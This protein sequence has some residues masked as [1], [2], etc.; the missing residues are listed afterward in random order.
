MKDRNFHFDVDRDG[1]FK[2]NAPDWEYSHDDRL[3][4]NSETGPFTISARRIDHSPWPGNISTPVDN[5][6]SHQ[7]PTMGWVAEVDGIEDGLTPEERREARAASAPADPLFIAKYKYI[8]AALHDKEI[9]IND[10]MTGTYQC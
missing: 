5:L 7:D 8:I 2:F 6:H 3:I 9:L 10:V 1:N 4:F